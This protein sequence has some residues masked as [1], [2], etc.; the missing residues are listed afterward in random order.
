[1]IWQSLVKLTGVA[2]VKCALY[3]LMHIM[4]DMKRKEVNDMTTL[5]IIEPAESSYNSPIVLVKKTAHRICLPS[6]L[7]A[8]D[9]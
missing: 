1:M 4:R 8:D 2:L 9:S 6:A 3:L 7:K 5:Y